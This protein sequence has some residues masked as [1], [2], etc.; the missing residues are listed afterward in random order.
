MKRRF[1]KIFAAVALL[2]FLAVPM[3]MWGQTYQ[4]IFQITSGDVVTNSSYAAYSNIVDMRNFVIT[5][6]GNNK[7]VGTNSSNR[8]NCNLSE[9]S[10]YA[11]SPVT[12]SSVASAF[13]CTTS[14]SDVS[15]IKYTFNGGSNQTS[16]NV[17]LL[18]SSDNSTFSQISLTS[19]TQGAAISSGTEYVFSE[20]DGYFA[21]LFVATNTSG[22]WRIDDVTIT[23]FE[24]SGPTYT[25][26]AQSNNTAYGTVSLSG[27]VITATP[28]NG[29]RVSTT[30]PYTV[31]PAN[32]A[33]VSQNGNEFTVTPSA[34][35]TV[36]INFEA[37]PTHTATFSVNGVVASS[38][39]VAEGADITF[40]ADPASINEKVFMGWTDAVIDGTQSTAPAFVTSAT[41]GNSD[42]IYYAVFATA[43]AGEPVETKAQ[44]LQYDSWTYR[45]STTDKS[46]YRLFH[47]GGY[48]E[49][50]A[51][52]LSKLS[53]VVVYGGT[54]GG[55]SYNS[56]TIGDGTNV[57][58]NVTVSGSSQTGVNTYTEG[59][60]LS[61]NGKLRVISNSG[62]ASSTG[63]RMS[64]V[65]I[66]VM[67]TPIVYSN[68]CTTVATDPSVTVTPA[69]INSPYTGAEGALTLTYENIENFISFD[70]YFCDAD[71]NELD[72]D[73]DWI[74]AEIQDENDTYSLY[75]IIGANNGAARTA[76]MK[77][78]TFDDNEEEVY[79]LVTIVQEFAPEPSITIDNATVNV[80]AD[81]HD[82]TLNLAYE[83]LPIE[84]M[85]DFDIQYYDAEGEEITEPDWIAVLV[86]EQDPTI[87]E[88][89]V[90]SYFML[91][92]EG[93][94]RSAYFK[95]FAA[96][97]EDFVYSNL[98]TISQGEAALPSGDE[99]VLTDLADLTADDI[100]VIVG[101]N[102]D[103]YAMPVDGGGQSGAPVAVAVTVVEGTLSGEPA[104][105]L[106]WNISG[107]ATD[108]YTFYPNGT[109]ET[110]LY[111]RNDNNGVRVGTNDNKVFTIEDGY[112]KNTAT[113]RY[114]GIYQSQDWRCY[115][116]TND[117]FPTNIAN[118][119]FAF[120]KK[121][122]ADVETYETDITVYTPNTKTG[123]HLI[124]SPLAGSVKAD[125]VTNLK[126]NT[127]DLYRFDQTQDME[128]Q[129]YKKHGFYIESGKGYLY[130][131]SGNGEDE[132]IT[133]TF[134]GQPYNGDGIVPLTYSTDNENENMHGW[135]LIGN[136]FST[137]ATLN[138]PFFKM[139]ETGSGFTSQNANSSVDK[140]EGVLVYA[141][142]DDASQPI[143]TA[144]F[145]A[146]GRSNSESAAMVN[147]NVVSSC[148]DVM[149]NAIVNFNEGLQLPKFY[150]GT[151][152]ANLYI[153]QGTEEYAIVNT[154]AQGEM[155]VNFRANE[156]GQYTLTV[157]P[158]NVGMN[159]L[160]LIDNMTG[161]DIDL[162]QTP[163]YTFN[164][165]VN[166]YE[167]RFRLVFSANNED[168]STGSTA[169]AF[170]SNGN[171]IVNNEGNA[172]LQ[173]IDI[174]GRI[175][176]SESISG[177]CS[178][179]INA[180]T[181][182]Y[183]LR[184]INGENVKVQKVVVR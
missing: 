125:N 74:Q 178:K 91:E 165:K 44:T 157:N 95:V 21:L 19:G 26:V 17:Y 124:A 108:G 156:D 175:L 34:N 89:Y 69:T 51:F 92:N 151:Q 84:N 23:F 154:E 88:G 100:F 98:V 50:A 80:D 120:Y 59:T 115:T 155:S 62:T 137:A 11:V 90:V 169:F 57:W 25:I 167:S 40:P 133:L 136:P 10:K 177:S 110:W 119:T 143:S 73:P 77:V 141:Y 173:V 181:G 47:N 183:M 27:N 46:S 116:L 75:Y 94:A 93:E 16:T 29:Y 123:W 127:Y 4:Q 76:Y 163:S 130:A 35:T 97:N 43:T 33:T 138:M 30:N 55:A 152:N 79:D 9:Y 8:S 82:G 48:V 131:N 99:W 7:S 153:P 41:M 70:Y 6:G 114:I 104:A 145:T 42:V 87:G 64:K 172:T 112:L 15:K 150:F 61:G 71:G 101:D 109:T 103:T 146:A 36:T 117:G 52:D 38:Q 66:F 122:S 85:E 128:W 147:I 179:A 24:S 162:L 5:F 166:D 180:T 78:Y 135:N 144:T 171:L 65:E 107:N 102:G 72:V 168:A 83:N 113:S 118:Q 37:I 134:E 106:Q 111:C 58:K 182:V 2:T 68:Y 20:C 60:A 184:L 54:F 13:A 176:S 32:S 140:M 3:V 67:E 148:G 45:G 22:N 126:S 174:N 159:Y 105:N 63:V 132:T 18:Y 81:E 121:V 164:A 96:G 86:A 14:I 161:M 56:L 149:D 1:T 160:H 31:S 142:D 139:N 129:N 53:K 39:T 28:E 158:E 12:T 49:S 170:F